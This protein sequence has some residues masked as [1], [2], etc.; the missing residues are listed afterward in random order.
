[1]QKKVHW[2]G[3]SGEERNKVIAKIKDVVSAH[4]GGITDFKMFSDLDLNL[5]I[6][7]E[8]DRI[9]ELH[10]ALKEILDVSD[11]DLEDINNESK[12]EDIVFLH[13][14]FS[15][16]KGELKIEIPEVPG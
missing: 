16:G 6:E 10:H 7:I 11:S 15:K 12:N 9:I 8:E 3:F 4:G 14:S 5:S 13:I 2:Q 1:M